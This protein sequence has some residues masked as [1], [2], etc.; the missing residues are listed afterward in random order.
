VQAGRVDGL[1]L[2]AGTDGQSDQGTEPGT[3]QSDSGGAGWTR[4]AHNRW[5]VRAAAIVTGREARGCS[6]A[7][8]HESADRCTPPLSALLGPDIDSCHLTEWYRDP[9]RRAFSLDRDA[10]GL[11]RNQVSDHRLLGKGRS[12][13]PDPLPPAR[14]SVRDKDWKYYEAGAIGFGV[15]T[16]T[17]LCERFRDPVA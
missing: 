6:D 17:D 10:S 2:L 11:A 9:L 14:Q 15:K 3:K 13:D 4:D 8:P 12:G 16:L 7:Q 5:S 1:P